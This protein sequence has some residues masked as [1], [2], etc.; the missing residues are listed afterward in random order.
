MSKPGH[1]EEVNLLSPPPQ[2]FYCKI[3]SYLLNDEQNHISQL[4]IEAYLKIP[5][6]LKWTHTMPYQQSFTDINL[7]AQFTMPVLI[8]NVHCFNFVII[9]VE[10]CSIMTRQ[11]LL[12]QLQLFTQ[13]ISSLQINLLYKWINSTWLYQQRTSEC[14]MWW[15]P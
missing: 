4:H 13:F 8:Y 2:K 9:I 3:F 7:I 10:H 11:I 14:G 1:S 6:S 12:L 5:D 15:L